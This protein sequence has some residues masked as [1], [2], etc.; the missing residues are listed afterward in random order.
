MFSTTTYSM[1]LAKD[2]IVEPI[3]STAAGGDGSKYIG[4]TISVEVF[5]GRY[6]TGRTTTFT[7]TTNSNTTSSQYL[8]VNAL[9]N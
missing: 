7:P 4:M 3:R 6:A 1:D 9:H 5:G 8:S 2:G